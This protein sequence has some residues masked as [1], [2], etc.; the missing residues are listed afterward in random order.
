VWLF[1]TA[2]A[3][4]RVGR[5]H[6]RL[7]RPRPPAAGR[8]APQV[9]SQRQFVGPRLLGSV[10]GRGDAAAPLSAGLDI[11]RKTL[12]QHDIAVVQSTAVDHA[13]GMVNLTTVLAHASGEWIAS[14]WPVCA[15][16]ETKT[17]HRMGASLTYVR[18][19][20]LFTLVGI[21]GRMTSTP[22]TL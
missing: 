7:P 20:A 16:S 13:A 6:L 5:R 2:H 12:G 9:L 21:A 18:R 19:Y 3:P 8:D 4:Q 10:P 1:S 17:P 15:I 11:A 14:D 22:Q